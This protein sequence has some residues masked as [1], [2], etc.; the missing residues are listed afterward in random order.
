MGF[1]EGRI[2]H[3]VS[4]MEEAPVQSL[5]V[6]EE[7][8]T[9]LHEEAQYRL[10][11]YLV[12]VCDRRGHQIIFST[13]SSVMLE[14]LPSDARRMLYRDQDGV[15]AYKGI[16][17]TRARAILSGGEHRNLTV[18]VEDAFAVNL[19]REI[20]RAEEPSLLKAVS[21]YETG[22]KTTVRETVKLLS[23]FQRIAIGIRDGDT[24]ENPAENLYSLPGT[25]APELEVFENEG[26]AN[27][28]KVKFGIDVKTIRATAPEHSHHD[29]PALLAKAAEANQEH[30]EIEAIGKYV[31][32]L[33]LQARKRLVE[34]I[35]AKA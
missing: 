22:S 2:L 16:S 31:E 21:I 4:Q 13:H 30:L 9:S 18:C 15:T 23:R 14:A 26:V 1:G 29:I 25:R 24:G 27:H 35:S 11:E 5:F 32:S 20:I 7:P 28:L 17:S 34:A 33:D 19:I 6:L 12:D 3:L 10:V 8:E